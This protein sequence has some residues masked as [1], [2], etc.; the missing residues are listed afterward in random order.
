MSL[1]ADG[2]HHRTSDG[3]VP[4]LSAEA[5]VEV[6]GAVI[7][8]PGSAT[9]HSLVVPETGA[10]QKL[11]TSARFDVAPG[12]YPVRTFSDEESL[13]AFLES[14]RAAVSLTVGRVRA[15]R[16]RIGHVYWPPSQRV[17][18]RMREIH[19]AFE[20]GDGPP[21]TPD[22]L[23]GIEGP[24]LNEMWEPV[25]PDYLVRAEPAGEVRDRPAK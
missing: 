2:W 11:K 20:A 3:L 21:L 13:A 7:V 5:R 6:R 1:E 15:P 22:A 23:Y 19:A 8:L 18:E 4:V 12:Q 9:Q 10:P 14:D 16:V 25:S 24:D 17:L